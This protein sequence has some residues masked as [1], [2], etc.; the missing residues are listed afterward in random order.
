MA[1]IAKSSGN[2]DG[3]AYSPIP[4]GNYVA[5]CYS[6]IDLGTR[7]EEILGQKK[8][9]HKVR[10]T[11]ELPTE[12]KVFNPEKG[13]QPCVISKEF[14]LSMNEK[15]NLRAF[16]TSWRG[17]AFTD[18]EAS[19]FDVT[20]LLGVP[21][22]L[23]IIH[24]QGRKDPSKVFDEIASATPI[25]K[26]MVCP[27]QVNPTFEFS[28]NEFDQAKFESMPNFLQEKI[29]GSDEY[30]ALTKPAAPQYT[31]AQQEAMLSEEH[32]KK[33]MMMATSSPSHPMSLNDSSDD[34]DLPF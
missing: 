16:L 21:C 11:F 1:I 5:R 12:L 4:A 8:V 13:E 28:I 18:E 10:I 9:V 19:A 34:L 32:Y 25:P 26:G 33:M 6:M 24:K 17:K 3:V 31:K 22:L 7:E 15:A 27:P 23:N 14:T 30:K 29:K 2:G 20:K